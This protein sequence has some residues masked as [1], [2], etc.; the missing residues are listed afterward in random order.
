MKKIMKLEMKKL[1]SKKDIML[2]LGIMMAIP[3]FLA[4][5]LAYRIGGINFGGSVSIDEYG[6]LIWSFLKYLFVLYILP[7]YVST[8][9]LGKEIEMRSINIMLSNKKRNEILV[10]KTLVYGIVLTIFF[11]LF[12]IISIISW[13]IFIEGSE[14]SVA[15]ENYVGYVPRIIGMYGFQW[16]ELMFVLLLSQF[17]CC[18]IKGNAALLIGLLIMILQRVLVNIDSIKRVLPYYIS[19]INSYCAIPIDS[20]VKTNAVSLSIYIFIIGILMFVSLMIWK[21]KDF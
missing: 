9:L 1:F 11:I 2:M 8:S 5:F 10:G 4:F 21:R 17:L 3:F 20:L 12:Q 13:K 16:L 15:I 6:A 7:I 18:L 14:Y 19:D